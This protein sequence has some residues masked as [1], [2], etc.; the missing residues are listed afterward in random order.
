MIIT[1]PFPPR[2]LSPNVSG[3]W[4]SK[5]TAKKKYKKDCFYLAKRE[6]AK[7]SDGNIPLIIRFYPPDKRRYDLDN[8]LARIKHGL[9]GVAMAFGINDV[10]FQPITLFLDKHNNAH[11]RGAVVITLE[12][13]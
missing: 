1:L 13:K 2:T 8:L 3:H 9:D 10:R 12:V 4:A 11:P 6:H 5:A 7:F